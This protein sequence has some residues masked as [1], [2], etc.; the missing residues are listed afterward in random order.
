MNET[1][2]QSR[3]ILSTAVSSCVWL[4]IVNSLQLVYRFYVM[5]M[6]FV[7]I[8]SMIQNWLKFE[9]KRVNI[10]HPLLTPTLLAACPSLGLQQLRHLQSLRMLNW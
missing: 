2:Q 6:L 1:R 4:V 8:Q 7:Y 5:G 3:V 9:Q 10:W